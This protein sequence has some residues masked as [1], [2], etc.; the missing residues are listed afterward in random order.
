MTRKLIKTVVM[1]AIGGAVI[2]SIVFGTDALS[3]VRSSSRSVQNAVKNSIPL[4]F[5]LQRARDMLEEIIPE[6]H[7]NIKLIAQEEVEIAALK[8]D[9]ERSEELLVKAE[10]RIEKL[11]N[12]HTLHKASYRFNS[13][14]VDRQQLTGEL[15][16]RFEQFTEAQ[17]IVES[18]RRLLSARKQSLQGAL[19]LLEKTRSQ[20]TILASKIETLESQHR[21]VQA[22]SVGAPVK[23]DNTKL[24]QTEKLLKHIKK[25]LDVA[26]RILA[27][28][29]HFVDPLALDEQPIDEEELLSQIDY[30]FN[31]GQ[32]VASGDDSMPLVVLADPGI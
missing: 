15:A 23:I 27:H 7:T 13:Q 8:S 24:A 4:R 11:R 32:K 17:V 16:H 2:G 9:I 28:Q 1:V 22:A 29:A 10:H 20:K 6:M 19:K 12:M 3:Y 21:L 5:E 26:E 25:R 31:S 30:Y 18:K 14:T